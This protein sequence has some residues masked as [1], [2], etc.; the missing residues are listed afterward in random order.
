M[1]LQDDLQA[2]GAKI[3]AIKTNTEFVVKFS[4]EEDD[5]GNSIYNIY[6][7]NLSMEAFR[8]YQ[9]AYFDSAAEALAYLDEM[10]E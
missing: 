5:D 1:T 4:Y 8:N 3:E 7:K 10:L 9:R 2:I 6:A